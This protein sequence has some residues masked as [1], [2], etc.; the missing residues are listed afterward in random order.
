MPFDGRLG[1]LLGQS[2]HRV[3]F[4]V[5][6]VDDFELASDAPD[7]VGD[8][9]V[10]SARL[11]R[12]FG[13]PFCVP[14]E[15]PQADDTERLSHWSQ[16]QRNMRDEAVVLRPTPPPEPWPRRSEAKLG[17][18]VGDQHDFRRSAPLNRRT[19][20]RGQ[21]PVR[22]DRPVPEEPVGSLEFGVRPRRLGEALGGVP[23]E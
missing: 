16:C 11:L 8:E 18:V 17:G 2:L 20:V 21:D 3:G 15:R 6:H 13:S 4:A 10:P 1:L 22:R 5:H 7:D 14:K 9:F 12:A 19:V 23:R